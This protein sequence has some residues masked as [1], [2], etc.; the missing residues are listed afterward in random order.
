MFHGR[1]QRALCSDKKYARHYAFCVSLAAILAN[2]SNN[3]KFP[4]RNANGESMHPP[5]PQLVRFLFFSLLQTCVSVT[6]AVRYCLCVGGC[7]SLFV[8]QWFVCCSFVCGCLV[9]HAFRCR[10][11]LADLTKQATFE[12]GSLL[13]RY[14]EACVREGVAVRWDTPALD[15]LLPGIVR[16][17]FVSLLQ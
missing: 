16:V 15:V 4:K 12:A 14:I 11:A 3:G 17:C 9:V 1:I 13:N 5:C 2:G 8:V 6:S 10:A 7:L